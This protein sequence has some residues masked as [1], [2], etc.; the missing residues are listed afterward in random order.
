MKSGVKIVHS[1]NNTTEIQN[2]TSFN[3]SDAT[4]G[5]REGSFCGILQGLRSPGKGNQMEV[6]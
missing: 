5:L 2:D 4:E 3:N 1:S 6:L